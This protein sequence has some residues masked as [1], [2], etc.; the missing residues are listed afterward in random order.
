LSPANVKRLERLA[1]DKLMKISVIYGRNKFCDTGRGIPKL[2]LNYL[3]WWNILILIS[4]FAS[5]KV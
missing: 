3:V 1:K 5:L 2:G 4:N